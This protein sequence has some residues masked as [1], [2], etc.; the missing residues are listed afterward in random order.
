MKGVLLWDNPLWWT[1]QHRKCPYAFIQV[2]LHSFLTLTLYAV[3]GQLHVLDTTC[4][5]ASFMSLT[6]HVEVSFM[7]LALRAVRSASCPWN[8]MWWGQ[9]HVLDTTCGDVSFMS[10]T[11]YAVGPASCPW[12][13]M[14]WGQ[15]H[16]LDTRC[17]EVSFMS[18]TAYAVRSASCPWH[19]MWRGQLRPWQYMQWGQLHVLDTTCGEVSFM[20]L[21]VYA[22]RSALCPWNYMR[23]GQVHVLDTTCEEDSFMSLT[24]HVKRSAS[25]PWH[26]T[27][28]D[29]PLAPTEQEAGWPQSQYKHFREDTS[30]CACQELI[31]GSLDHSL[32][33]V[34][35][36]ER[37]VKNTIIV[38]YINLATS[39]DLQS[40]H[41]AILNC[42]YVGTLGG[43]AHIWD[44]KMFTE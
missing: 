20:S 44:P 19:Y 42:I 2:H 18:L 24:L 5:E 6:L 37:Y 26:C 41:Q 10:L 3:R 43:S 38:K 27:P 8:Y 14:Q 28:V 9:L 16:V 39:S 15:L 30:I 36:R 40:H 25:C 34:Y 21:T 22:V 31:L 7:S 32:Y 35:S 11:V 23:W 13:Y 12:N 4:S 17:G 1:D 33:T 29:E